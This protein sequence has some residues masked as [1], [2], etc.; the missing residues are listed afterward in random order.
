MVSRAAAVA[1]IPGDLAAAPEGKATSGDRQSLDIGMTGRSVDHVRLSW[2]V[3][4]ESWWSS[5]LALDRAPRVLANVVWSGARSWRSAA[6]VLMTAVNE[7]SPVT[8]CIP[9]AISPVDG[10][11]AGVDALH[12]FC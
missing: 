5:K 1:F 7:V 10:P 12:Q 6:L 3:G 11:L 8:S 9:V 2:T 4:H